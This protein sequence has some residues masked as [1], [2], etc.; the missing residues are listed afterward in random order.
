MAEFPNPDFWKVLMEKYKAGN[1]KEIYDLFF[2]SNIL[3]YEN[4]EALSLI[5]ELKPQIYKRDKYALRNFQRAVSLNLD[6][7]YIPLMIELWEEKSII[8]WSTFLYLKEKRSKDF[9][10]II[11]NGL[12]RSDS[13][14][15]FN[16]R[17]TYIRVEKNRITTNEL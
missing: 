13:T 14:Y 3:S 8:N 17:I 11:E 6:E 16:L 4:K 1:E 15:Y 10:T 12:L 7:K 9:I 5:E 2:L